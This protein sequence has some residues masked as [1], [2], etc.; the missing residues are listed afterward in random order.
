M[1][2]Q[3]WGRTICRIGIPACLLAWYWILLSPT[4]A[5]AH[6]ILLRSN[7]PIGA[8]LKSLPTRV[9]MWFNGDLNPTFTKAFVLDVSKS[10]TQTLDN[11]TM[12]VDLGDAHV[13]AGDPKEVEL[14]LK[15]H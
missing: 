3:K 5:S 9:Q 10:T 11:K 13:V 15:P 7:P 1:V 6:A 4:T 8:V 2:W 12:H 14:S